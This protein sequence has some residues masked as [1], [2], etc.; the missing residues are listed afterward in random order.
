MVK[1]VQ[2][3]THPISTFFSKINHIGNSCNFPFVILLS[4]MAY[5][6]MKINLQVIFKEYHGSLSLFDNSWVL[7][8]VAGSTFLGFF[9]DRFFQCSWRK[10]I[11]LIGIFCSFITGVAFL[12]PALQDST[13]KFSILFFVLLNGL[14][15]SYLG[16]ARAFYLDQFHQNKVFHFAIT[17]VFQC[18]PW[19]L[20]GGLLTDRWVSPSFLHYFAIA[21]VAI[22][23]CANIFFARD[24][25]KP[26]FESKHGRD[27]LKELSHKYNHV[28]YWSILLSFF[29][30]AI[31][32]HLMP[33]LGEY[34]FPDAAFYQEVFLLGLGVGAGVP[35]AFA[36]LKMP[37]LRTLKIGY[38]ICFIYFFILGFLY[39]AGLIN[40]EKT[41]KYQ[42]L[43]FAVFGG[44]LWILSLKEFL[45]K[46][47]LTEDGLV[48]GFIES[49]QSL[50]EF[51]GAGL[52]TLLSSSII[53]KKEINVKLFLILLAAAFIIISIDNVLKRLR[54]KNTN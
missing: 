32:Y 49:I 37:T 24:N 23:F 19:V 22:A 18:I 6:I 5:E 3:L 25:R 21:I 4:I 13:N 8:S 45:I 54:H 14:S 38:A 46:S 11:C 36:F 1:T 15:G 2:K 7:S 30:L 35:I 43:I 40:S 53:L 52:S 12:H 34:T 17:V 16:A 44:T 9:S 10:P 42:F 48:L 27:E 26:Y 50:G 31:S 39:W 20:I 47:K 29:I 51:A 41:L 28:K 33:Y